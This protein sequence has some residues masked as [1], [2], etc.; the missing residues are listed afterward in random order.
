MSKVMFPHDNAVKNT[1]SVAECRQYVKFTSNLA[2]RGLIE[3]IIRGINPSWVLMDR[4]AGHFLQD[5][6]DQKRPEDV[7]VRDLFARACLPVV[8]RESGITPTKM[9]PTADRNL[10]I[11][12][13]NDAVKVMAEQ[14]FGQGEQIDWTLVIKSTASDKR[15]VHLNGPM[16]L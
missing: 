13:L 3:E 10:A 12:Q 8:C 11:K 9:I 14:L 7:L 15:S 6:V 1:M 5:V 16:E 2:H 4:Q